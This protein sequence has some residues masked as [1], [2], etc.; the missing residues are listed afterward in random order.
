MYSHLL[1]LVVNI[2]KR[3]K[4]KLTQFYFIKK[5]LKT[6]IKYLSTVLLCRQRLIYSTTIILTFLYVDS[7]TK[8]I[9]SEVSS[10][11]L[12]LMFVNSLSLKLIKCSG[13]EN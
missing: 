5:Q 7:I 8:I 1:L 4:I 11:G 6:D 3:Q 9:P 10:T 13:D 12:T 2:K